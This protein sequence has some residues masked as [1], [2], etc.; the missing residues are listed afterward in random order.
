V[1]D[2]SGTPIVPGDW[3]EADASGHGVKSTVAGHECIA[4]ALYN[5][6]AAGDII[7][8]EVVKCRF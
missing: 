7:E 4:R 2:G 5:S 6:T 3:L 8:V 1:V